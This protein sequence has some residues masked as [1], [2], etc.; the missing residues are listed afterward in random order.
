MTDL[1]VTATLEPAAG[2]DMEAVVNT[3][4]FRADVPID[5]AVVLDIH[6]A[7]SQFYSG[8]APGATFAL[9]GYLNSMI[10]RAVSA[11]SLKMY[12]ITG[13]L[14]GS[15]HGS[16]I[17]EDAFTLPAAINPINLPPQAAVVLTLRGRD[18]LEMPV[19]GALGIRPR[20]RRSGR[21]FFGSLNRAAADDTANAHSRPAATLRTDL[22]AAAEALQDALVDGD[23]IWGVWSRTAET[24]LGIERVEVDDSFDVLR[25]RKLAPSV[26]Q[27][28]TFV[29]EPALV[30]G[31]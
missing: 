24:I 3:F 11:C 28:R 22:M 30:L 1:L 21:L 9:G 26:R 8:V 23:Y 5:A 16:P 7:V 17:A 12:D 13:H 18:A 2:F 27:S 31:A 6:N 29:P 25:S 10:S 4:A 14:D 19:E 20:Q 15:P